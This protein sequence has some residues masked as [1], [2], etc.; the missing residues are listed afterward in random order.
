MELSTHAT[1]LYL[2]S[3]HLK[4]EYLADYSM[5]ETR[6]IRTGADLVGLIG[7]VDR[8]YE[9]HAALRAHHVQDILAR[10]DPTLAS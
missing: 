5:M 4:L 2:S 10:R 8:R 3:P 6:S 9:E 1:T 7:Y